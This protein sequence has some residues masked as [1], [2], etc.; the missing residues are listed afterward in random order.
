MNGSCQYRPQHRP[1]AKTTPDDSGDSLKLRRNE[2]LRT[3]AGQRSSRRCS[4]E[5]PAE[6]IL[7]GTLGARAKQPRQSTVNQTPA[8]NPQV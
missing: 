4:I 1:L 7:T 6:T 3:L 5:R 8:R 2:A